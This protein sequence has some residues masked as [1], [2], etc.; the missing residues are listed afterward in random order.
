MD[1]PFGV[2]PGGAWR[3]GGRQQ[4]AQP[5]LRCLLDQYL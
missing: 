1:F 5:H 3:S 4:A 2:S